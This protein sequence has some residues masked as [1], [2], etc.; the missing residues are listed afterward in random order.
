MNGTKPRMASAEPAGLRRAT[1]RAAMGGS[2]VFLS[3]RIS[4]RQARARWLTSRSGSRVAVRSIG[5]TSE[6]IFLSSMVAL[7]R[8]WKSSSPSWTI[9]LAPRSRSASVRVRLRN[10]SSGAPLAVAFHQASQASRHLR[11]DSAVSPSCS[12]GPLSPVRPVR[13]S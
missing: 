2:G 4:S 3:W 10:S 6:P 11:R 13:N 9:S 5:T 8:T 7:L 1:T 12:L